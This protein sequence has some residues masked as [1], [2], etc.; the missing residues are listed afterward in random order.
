[1]MSQYTEE[2]QNILDD[3]IHALEAHPDADRAFVEKIKALVAQG[4]I[5]Q[6]QAIQKAITSLEEMACDES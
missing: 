3:F 6:H 1:M 4:K 2:A 5:A